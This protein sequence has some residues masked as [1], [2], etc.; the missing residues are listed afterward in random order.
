MKLFA[1]KLFS[2]DLMRRFAG[3]LLI[4]IPF[5]PLT[6]IFADIKGVNHAFTPLDWLYGCLIVAGV[7]WLVNLLVPSFLGRIGQ[8]LSRIWRMIGPRLPLI[9]PWLIFFAAAAISL[10]CFQ[11]RPHLVDSVV[12]LFQAKIFLLA[13]LWVPPPPEYAFFM[14]QHM[15]VAGGKWFSQYPPGYSLLLALGHMAHA[16]W[17][18]DAALSVLTAYFICALTREIFDQE[19]AS[20]AA[21][22]LLLCPFFI[23]MGGGFMNHVPTLCFSSGA[24]LFFQRW[25]RSAAL[26]HM[27]CAALLLGLAFLCRP[28]DAVIIGACLGAFL[29]P[30]FLARGKERKTLLLQLLGGAL[31]CS[32]AGSLFFIYNAE[33]TGDPFLPGYIKQWGEGHNLGFHKDPWGYDHTPLRGLRNELVDIG[34]LHEFL[35]ET[36]IPGMIFLGFYLLCAPKISRWEG[37]LL[38]GFFAIPATYF[39]YWHRDSFLGPRFLY[40]GLVFLIPLMSKALKECTVLLNGKIFNAG[41]TLSPIPAKNIFHT[42]LGLSVIYA[43]TMGVPLR[44][45][46]CA[47]SFQSMKIDVIAE[48]KAQG[49]HDGLIFIPVSWGSRMLGALRELE[50]PANVAQESYSF[51]DHCLLQELIDAA[52]QGN[53]RGQML[54][55]ELT[56]LQQRKVRIVS[57]NK[58]QV[59]FADIA[60]GDASLKLSPDMPVK[61]RC[62]E[63]LLY[64]RAGYTNFMPFLADNEPLLDGAF[65]IANDLRGR[66]TELMRRYPGKGAYLYRKGVFEKMK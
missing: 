55:D 61:P 65:V 39:F 32:A 43:L 24:I 47:S 46:I 12:Q 34:L 8:L 9:A 64:D 6:R 22:L 17:M 49:I 60:N 38:S 48:A 13:R 27:L 54:V 25:E 62:V 56:K 33:T 40:L 66:N 52:R 31:L 26:R 28:L 50:V 58:S 53:V 14:T 41:G 23:F 44:F 10:F 2:A 35:F 20:L 57:V 11:H 21:L 45:G 51:N 37:R 18:I 59:K 63:E 42:A 4:V 7:S 3:L 1:A 16:A 5:I 29:L 36:P 30:G 15:V 19:S